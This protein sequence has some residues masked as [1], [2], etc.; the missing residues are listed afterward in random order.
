MMNAIETI[1]RALGGK[2]KPGGGWMCRCPAH[3]DKEPSLSIDLGD[4]LRPVVKCWAGCSNQDVISA[5]RARGLWPELPPLTGRAQPAPEKRTKETNSQRR[6]D[7]EAAA[8][9]AVRRWEAAGPANRDHPYLAGKGLEGQG[10][11][12][13]GRLLLVPM[14]DKEGT[15]CSLQTINPEGQKRFLKGGAV[16]GLVVLIGGPPEPDWPVCVVEGWAT[17]A[18]I[19]AA[20]GYPAAV[21]FSATNLAQ[22]AGIIQAKHP[23]HQVI[24]CADD[25]LNPDKENNTGI[26]AATAAAASVGGALAVPGMGKKADF[27]D[28]WH[29]QGPDAV[30][31]VIADAKPVDDAADCTDHNPEQEDPAAM[32]RYLAGLSAL[33][34]EQ[35]RRAVAE[36]LG[37][38]ASALDR[39]VK[40]AGKSQNESI[41]PFDEPDPWP[42]PVEPSQLLTNIAATIQRFII[43]STE[44]AHAVA[45]WS[46]MTWFMDVVQVAPLAII[47][48][49]EKRCGKSQLL[50]LLGRLSARSIT[51]SSISPAALYRAIDAWQP[52][53][54]ID[55]ADAFLKDNE[56]LRGIINSG[57]TR[58]S[59]YVIRTVG[60]NFTPTKFNT[61]G[62]KAIAGIGHVADTIMDRSV[63]LEL[64]RKLPHEEVARLRYAEADLFGN[65]R[66]KLARFADD[67]AAMVRQTR[68]PLPS[69]LNDRA[70][71]N[72]EPLL[73][74]AMVA[75]GHWLE[76][77]TR[78]AI[79]LSGCESAAQTIGGE[80]LADIKE[81]FEMRDTDR[82]STA[83]LIRALCDDDEKA[84][85]TYNRGNPISPR[86]LANK[87][88]GYGIASNTLRFRHA[89]LAKGYERE[90]FEEA[91]SRYIPSHPSTLSVTA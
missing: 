31:K 58:D 23:G 63:I 66:A 24:L 60:D 52:T 51:A 13:D 89:G 26:D 54:L 12:Q 80:L 16:S 9:E 62:A 86:Q 33:E 4:N 35:K 85:A 20:T 32:I 28:L 77:G 88:K 68:P 47:T 42:E 82:I 69:C 64:R 19:H 79:K 49:P 74:I 22:V 72:W 67:Y 3:D 7:R 81:I 2:Q 41:L 53:L 1:G 59:A 50:F 11:R 70:Q 91:F 61:W 36:A 30:R 39:A 76:I 73:A 27:W 57:H 46:A 84:W 29:E 37:V 5:L 56:E 18:A 55:E 45:L 25:D 43:C 40:E 87:L 10:L 34:Y 48:A 78:A 83:D 44:V 17:G 71:D 6:P 15:V 38:R 90:Q 8:A 65:L 14:C 21:A 75:G